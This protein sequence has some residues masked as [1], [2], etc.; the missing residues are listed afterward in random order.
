VI[1]PP[2]AI[3]LLDDEMQFGAQ[4]VLAPFL[5]VHGV[6]LGDTRVAE[7]AVRAFPTTTPQRLFCVT[8]ALPQAS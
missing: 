2:A 8:A 7:T 4:Y 5:N 1:W 6:A 3:H